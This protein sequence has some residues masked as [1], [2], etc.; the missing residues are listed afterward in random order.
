MQP[1]DQ[2]NSRPDSQPAQARIGQARAS[3]K[4]RADDSLIVKKSRNGGDIHGAATLP[5]D[6]SAN[7][8]AAGTNLPA[9]SVPRLLGRVAYAGARRSAFRALHLV[10]PV[11]CLNCDAPMSAETPPDSFCSACE[12][13]LRRLTGPVCGRCG[14]ALGEN[15][16]VPSFPDWQTICFDCFKKP[17]EYHAAR[18][19]FSYEGTGRD[20]VIGLKRR[21]RVRVAPLLAPAL[22][23][24]G[25]D[26]I[27]NSDVIVPVPLAWQRRVSR[28][29]NQSALIA[30]AIAG[31]VGLPTDLLGLRRIRNTPSQVPRRRDERIANVRAAFCLR[32]AGDFDGLRV[33]LIDD[34][35]TTGATADA[36]A[37]I[38]FH[39]GARE[40]R[41]LALARKLRNGPA[42][43]SHAAPVPPPR[44]RKRR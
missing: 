29:F 42:P 24:V 2:T 43:S 1:L 15:P 27:A 37:R 4:A 22:V 38:F 34:V 8:A 28:R 9:D 17:P 36:C 16:V 13:N 12:E 7:R 35:I 19:L 40:V 23:R 25:A 5:A 41:V 3:A 30:R 6:N 44:G 31:R 33:L 26:F 39:D 20:L 11:T 10:I 14:A 21:Q 18:A 32:R